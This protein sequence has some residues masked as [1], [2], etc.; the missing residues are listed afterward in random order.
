MTSPLTYPKDLQIGQ[1]DYVTFTHHEY[2]TN[3]NITGS[4]VNPGG[5]S[6]AAAPAGG[7]PIVL[8]MPT[9]TPAMSAANDWGAV[10]FEG[11]L[12]A[13]MGN[14]AA[15]A[16]NR[17]MGMT[18]VDY[19]SVK[20]FTKGTIDEVKNQVT[21]ASSMAGGAAQQFGVNVISELVPANANQLLAMSRGQIFN[22]NVELLYSGPK[23]RGFS[24]SFTFVP[25]SADEAVV[26]NNIIK[27]FKKWSAPAEIPG[28]MY[29]VPDVW[30]VTYMHNNDVNRNMNAF[31]KAA[32]TNVAVQSNPGLDMH[33]TFPNGMPVLTTLSLNFTEVDVI[34]RED[35]DSVD[36]NV[37]Y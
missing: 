16:T 12:G 31:K 2:R 35:H 3:R 25:K 17:V 24:M 8:Y 37:G 15:G 9:S 13:V 11:N 34:L 5:A 29:K 4:N 19:D 23:V 36:S 20:Q 7:P 32:L 14:L 26:V 30:Q 1:V 6:N 27:E 28:G 33:M 21:A 10:N 22:P 18:G